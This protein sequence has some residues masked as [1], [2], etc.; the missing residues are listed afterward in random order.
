MRGLQGISGRWSRRWSHSVSGFSAAR[1]NPEC[2]DVWRALFDARKAVVGID[3]IQAQKAQFRKSQFVFIFPFYLQKGFGGFPLFG[4]RNKP[5]KGRLASGLLKP[6]ASVG[7]K[8]PIRFLG[9]ATATW[10]RWESFRSLEWKK[11]QKGC[12][13]FIIW[14]FCIW[15]S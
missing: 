7:E 1:I 4:H 3:F 9:A 12:I 15:F 14:M 8:G 2:K 11:Q 5:T 10:Q 6:A 13:C